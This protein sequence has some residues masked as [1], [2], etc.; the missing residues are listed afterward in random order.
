[1][2]LSD[3][4]FNGGVS[5]SLA[6]W[7]GS[8]LILIGWAVVVSTLFEAE[9]HRA[10]LAT[11]IHV[12]GAG[13]IPRRLLPYRLGPLEESPEPGEL[14]T[15]LVE[16]ETAAMSVSPSGGGNDEGSERKR[17]KRWRSRGARRRGRARSAGT[18]T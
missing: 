7:T 17:F 9:L 13:S 5:F 10:D 11:V 12:S 8:L 16:I 6:T 18:N 2:P 14:F 1:V 4:V 15:R 3:L